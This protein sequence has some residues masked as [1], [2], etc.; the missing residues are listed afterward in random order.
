MFCPESDVKES[1]SERKDTSLVLP[2]FLTAQFSFMGQLSPPIPFDSDRESLVQRFV[3]SPL[4][5]SRMRSVLG[6]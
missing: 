1:S 2:F 4:E 5:L 3:N 6:L